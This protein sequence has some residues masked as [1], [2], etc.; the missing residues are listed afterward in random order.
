MESAPR[1]R[2]ERGVQHAAP[3]IR[4]ALLAS[5]GMLACRDAPAQQQSPVAERPAI[6]D[7][8]VT[9]ADAAPGRTPAE[10]KTGMARWKDTVVY[11]DGKPIG[12]L[13]FGELPLALK[14]YWRKVKKSANKPA[15]CPECLA[16]KW[17]EQRFYRFTEYLK[18]MGIPIAKIKELHVQ[19]PKI[20]ETI[21]ATAKDL[22]SPAGGPRLAVGRVRGWHGGL[23]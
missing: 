1:A 23:G 11:L 20:T 21:V 18:A 6:R 16:W 4:L 12:Y 10:Y 8:G 19:G 5:I 3:V 15:N 9:P 2:L 22:A 14:P 7:A 17:G 13:T